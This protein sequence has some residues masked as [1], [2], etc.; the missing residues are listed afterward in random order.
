MAALQE[1]CGVMGSQFSTFVHRQ[2][3]LSSLQAE[4]RS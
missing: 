4:E 3:I 1:P 2:K